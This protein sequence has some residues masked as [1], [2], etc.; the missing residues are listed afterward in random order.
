MIA[1][2]LAGI[3]EPEVVLNK[4]LPRASFRPSSNFCLG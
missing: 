3:D 2:A 1:D 4:V